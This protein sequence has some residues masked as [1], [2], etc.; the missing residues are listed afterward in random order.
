[1]TSD[2]HEVKGEADQL[3]GYTYTLDL[4]YPGSFFFQLVYEKNGKIRKHRL[5]SYRDFWEPVVHGSSQSLSTSKFWEKSP[6][7][8]IY[9]FDDFPF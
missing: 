9:Q 8:S 7:Y 1:M 5:T 3:G 4:E 6:E 2:L